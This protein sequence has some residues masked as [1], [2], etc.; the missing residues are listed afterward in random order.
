MCTTTLREVNG[1]KVHLAKYDPNPAQLEVTS[2]C[3]NSHL[4]PWKMSFKHQPLWQWVLVTKSPLEKE[5]TEPTVMIGN[6][7]EHLPHTGSTYLCPE[8]RLPTSLLCKREVWYQARFYQKLSDRGSI[9]AF[10]RCVQ[11]ACMQNTGRASKTNRE[12]RKCR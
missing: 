10:R 7:Q 8:H 2:K 3:W 9:A 11:T 5:Q 12:G 1:S 6:L 4:S